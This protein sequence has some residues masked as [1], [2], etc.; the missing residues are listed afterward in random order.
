MF[1][2]G[3][4]FLIGGVVGIMMNFR[5]S[6]V[7]PSPVFALGNVLFFIGPIV[8]GIRSLSRTLDQVDYFAIIFAAAGLIIMGTSL[9]LR[10]RTRS[11]K[12]LS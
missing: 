4:I 2:L 12:P 8:L 10:R 1:V 11:E 9:L 3:L 5:I 7:R 6:A